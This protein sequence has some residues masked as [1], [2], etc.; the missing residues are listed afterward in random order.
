MATFYGQVA[1]NSEIV[2]ARQ[3]S[4]D[5]GIHSSAQSYHGS[6]D[7]SLR[8]KDKE[9]VDSLMVKI[10]ISN[11]SSMYGNN[12]FYGTIEELKQALEMYMNYKRN[13]SYDSTK[14]VEESYEY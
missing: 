12:Y 1:G 9:I 8:Y 11:G 2:V 3:G 7:V 13:I 10:G 5:S 4:F 14:E 6:V